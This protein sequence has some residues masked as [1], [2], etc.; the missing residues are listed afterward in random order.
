ME[1]QEKCKWCGKKAV[2]TELITDY[3]GESHVFNFCEDNRCIKYL[4]WL[5]Q[6]FWNEIFWQLSFTISFIPL[7]LVIFSIVMD[8]LST[9]AIFLSGN[10]ELLY[11]QADILATSAL[12]F[13]TIKLFYPGRLFSI[14]LLKT[15]VKESNKKEELVG[16]ALMLFVTISLLFCQF[17]WLTYCIDGRMAGNTIQQKLFIGVYYNMEWGH[18]LLYSSTGLYIYFS[19]FFS[20]KKNTKFLEID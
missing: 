20:K 18:Y 4:N 11:Y 15:K 6:N 19:V 14:M 10:L 9:A 1:N 8:L 3:R 13:I 16:F 12:L 17:H 5:T 2:R 7:I